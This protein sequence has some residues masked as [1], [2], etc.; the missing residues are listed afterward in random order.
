MNKA[1]AP[2][3]SVADVIENPTKCPQCGALT[4][5]DH[6]ICINCLLREGLEAK[7]EASR[8]A[9]ESILAEADVTDTQWRLG[10]YEILEE[11][12]RGGMG[13][14]YRARQQ[15][16]RRIVAVKRILAHEVN[17]HETLV[18]FRREAEAVASLDH[19]NILPIHEIS[20]SEEGLPFFSMKYAT[21][22]SLR[23]AAPTLRAKPRECVRLM[24]KVA[25][26]IAYAHGKGILHRD[27]QPGNILLDENGEPMVSDFGLAK[28]LDKNSDL[29]RTLETLGTPGYIAPEQTECPTADLTGAADI[30]SLGAIL[31]YLLTGRPPFVGPNVLFVIHQAAASPAPRLRS[32]APSLDRDLET[33][34]ARCLESDPN[35]RYQS[36][37]A[38]ADDLEH[39]L[40]HEP[41]RARRSGVFTRGGKWVRRNPTSAALV[42]SLIALGAVVG[43][44]LW[45]SQSLHPMPAG[46]AVLPF[47]NLST[48]PE[49]VFFTYG[50][51]DEILNG[52]AK[53][54]DLKV[55]S[56][57]SVMQYESGVK[58]NLRQIA[59]ELGVAHVVEG[60]VQRAG[61]RVRVTA[62]LI[63]AKTDTHLWVER[64]DRPL[65]DVF[66]IQS[67]IAKAI[68]TQLQAKLSP[69][70]KAAIEQ[71]PTTNL[72]AYD[73]YLRAEK[74]F[75][76]TPDEVSSETNR[77]AIR[78]LDQAVG[79]DPTFLLAYCLLSRIHA[80]LYFVGF[81]H[82]AARVALAKEARDAALRL[83]PDRGEPHLAAAWVAYHCYLNYE[84]AL[85]EVDIARRRLPN[86]TAVYEIT[87]LI[88]RRQGHSQQCKSNLERAVDLDP[89]SASLVQVAAGTY[90][91]LRRFSEA[92]AAWDRA[93]A[94]APG[95]VMSR[96]GRTQVDLESRADTRPMYEVI[97]SIITE[98]PSAVDAIGER[99]LYFALCRRDAAEMASAL[100]SL[101]LEVLG[102]WNIAV[103]RSFFEGLAARARNDATA[104]DKA[105][106]AA[107]VEM[108]KIVREQPD[109]P[110]ALCA[111]GMI[112]AALGRKEDA[113]REGRRA[114]EVLPITRDAWSGANLLTNLAII[115]AWVGEKDLA[116]KQLEEVVRIPSPV[117][118][119]QL[120]LHPFW[121]PLR[122]DSRFEK[123]VASLAPK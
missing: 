108:G 56:R 111:L 9:F 3:A 120:R 32:L 114:V 121:D 42:A 5:L 75:L 19:P 78:L 105:F 95:D 77:Q 34:V 21:G 33:V 94:I 76:L 100:A 24:A 80:Y 10:H 122:G 46:I 104:A 39:W 86:D 119:G 64:Y 96:V 81:D 101:P 112:D 17:S 58:R 97:Q 51:Q 45:E 116:I 13:V 1:T 98:D 61:N 71:P 103:P 41:I 60:S 40:H 16:S 47:E 23:T 25:R 117:S 37:E 99:W 55:I 74:L 53:I 93:L 115:Y 107:R 11:I 110:E 36:A 88:A 92:A 31:F 65:D 83:S 67:E 102:W 87:S 85:A 91:E 70:E 63:D 6:G 52:L 4:R 54:A 72:I 106:T 28:W 49:N 109:Y 73:H 79:H 20:E 59:N 12:G 29:T 62:Q 35:V 38:L 48:D 27:L 66:G 123:I 44:V 113:L 22:G 18:R 89:R 43:E 26:A 68:A 69:A 82:T 2:S 50:V 15:H 30:Y 14:I 84:T 57:T 118:Y 8:E 7:G 90:Q